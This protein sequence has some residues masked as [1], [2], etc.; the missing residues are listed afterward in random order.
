MAETKWVKRWNSWIAPKPSKPGVW[1]RKEGGHLV[2]GRAI[3][4]RSGTIKQVRMVL[5]ETDALVAFELLQRELRTIREGIAVENKPSIGFGEFAATLFEEKVVNGEIKSAAGRDK[6]GGILE[7]HIVPQLGPIAVDKLRHAD[8]VAWRNE[9]GAKIAAGDYAP[10]TVNGWIDVLRVLTKAAVARYELPRDPMVGIKKFDTSEH[11]YTEEEPNS[12]TH[13]ELGLFLATLKEKY[14]QHYAFACLGF[15][16]GQRPSTLR[17]LRRKGATPDFDPKTGVLLIRRSQVKGDEVMETTKTKIRQKI[18][19]PPELVTILEQHVEQLPEG[20]MRDSDL[21][22]PS[23]T[24]GHR[25]RSCLDR[26][27]DVVRRAIGLKKKITPKAM[28]RSFQDLARAAEVKD[29]VTRAISGHAT[30]TMQHHYSTVAE[31]E[32]RQAIAKVIT[33]AGVSS[34]LHGGLHAQE[35]KKAA[36]A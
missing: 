25:S 22:F 27:F 32:K 29:I 7:H 33:L 6:W 28:R 31:A 11:G 13:E 16:L 26:P 21:L 5:L 15:F 1:R 4:P 10:S 20:P 36:G 30:E 8:M 24:G 14:P 3:D 23:E 17:P 12:C 9:A 19:L 34:G 35:R 18:V 2:R